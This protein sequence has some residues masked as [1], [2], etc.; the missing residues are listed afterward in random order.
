MTFNS[1]ELCAGLNASLVNENVHYISQREWDQDTLIIIM[2]LSAKYYSV[3]SWDM[4]TH[5][6]IV[7][8]D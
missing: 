3:A 2:M 1:R 7:V 6:T 8:S 4:L 5:I